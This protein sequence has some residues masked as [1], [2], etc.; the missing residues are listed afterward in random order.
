VN[1][2]LLSSTLYQAL[3]VGQGIFYVLALLGMVW[4]LRP[5]VLMLPYY[6]SMIN[7]AT[8]FGFY[9]A[10]TSRRGMAWK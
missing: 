9:H 10:M 8:F 1:L 5:K 6:F 2:F 4:K 7:A 3:L